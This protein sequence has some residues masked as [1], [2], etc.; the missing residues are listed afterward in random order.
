MKKCIGETKIL[1]F[2]EDIFGILR[3][4]RYN[5]LIKTPMFQR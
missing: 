1:N 3:L 5:E 2:Y 4:E